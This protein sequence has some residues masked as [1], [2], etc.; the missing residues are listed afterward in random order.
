[1]SIDIL[2]EKSYPVFY[3]KLSDISEYL[4]FEDKKISILLDF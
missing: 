4:Y 1:M 2:T 3:T